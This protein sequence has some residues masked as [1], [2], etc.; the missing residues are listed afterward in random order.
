MPGKLRLVGLGDLDGRTSAAK[1]ARTL[2]IAFADEL[3]GNLTASQGAAVESA[4][5]LIALAEDV[6]ARRLAGDQAISLEDVVRIDNAA[7]RALRV[8][9]IKPGAGA[10]HIPLRE[11]LLAERASA[12]D[13]G[14]DEA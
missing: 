3:G 11:Q 2:V 7:A 1:R 9:G 10:Q 6:R 5:P 4:A 12:E 8:L 14:G 13:A